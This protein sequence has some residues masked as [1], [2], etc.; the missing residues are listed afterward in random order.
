MAP[1]ILRENAAAATA[2]CAGTAIASC[3]HKMSLEVQIAQMRASLGHALARRHRLGAEGRWVSARI[4][5]TSIALGFGL[6]VW[7]LANSYLSP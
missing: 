2:A 6:A 1:S 4:S 5:A 3:T 7:A